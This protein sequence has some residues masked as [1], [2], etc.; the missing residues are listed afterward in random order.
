MARREAGVLSPP[1]FLQSPQVLCL[2]PEA[3]VPWRTYRYHSLLYDPP[4]L[5]WRPIASLRWPCE[6]VSRRSH[7]EVQSPS[8]APYTT[9]YL[10]P[11]EHEQRVDSVQLNVNEALIQFTFI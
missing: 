2:S 6:Q 10:E 7:V 3:R 9:I 1:N 11:N 8:S 4:A 5:R